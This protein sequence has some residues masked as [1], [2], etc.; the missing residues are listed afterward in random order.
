MKLYNI[1]EQLIL[2]SMGD[3]INQV[4]DGNYAANGRK[5]FNPVE[6]TY[7]SNKSGGQLSTRQVMIYGRG[8]LKGKNGN[9]AIRV[10]QPFGDTQS[11]NSTWKTF[12]VN[13]ITNIKIKDFKFFM[14]PSDVSGGSGIPDYVGPKDEKFKDD[15]L[16]RYVTFD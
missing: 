14:Q 2:E 9:D 6:I 5:Y 4:I 7:R 8:I 13:N 10:F 16:Q 1:Y 11:S 15:K 3:T 12:L